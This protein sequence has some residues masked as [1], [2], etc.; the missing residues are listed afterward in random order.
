MALPKFLQPCLWSYDLSQ[1]NPKEDKITII[2]QILNFG[3][4]RDI[5][6][7]FKTYKVSEIKSVLR[8]PRRGLWLERI[9]N[10]WTKILNVTPDPWFHKFCI[11]DINP[12]PKLLEEF[13]K[14]KPQPFKISKK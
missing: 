14:S 6:W 11:L 5:R 7:L 3:D 10:Y 1:M 2:T 13:F 9:I 12:N 8:K 4:K